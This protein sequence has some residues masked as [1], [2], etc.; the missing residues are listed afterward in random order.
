[1]NNSQL[2]TGSITANRKD[3]FQILYSLTNNL[4]SVCFKEGENGKL[5][6]FH[7]G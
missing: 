7:G 4:L 1:M 3:A 5:I 2:A 6:Y